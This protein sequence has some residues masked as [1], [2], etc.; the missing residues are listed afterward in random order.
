[1]IA[2]RIDWAELGRAG[3]KVQRRVGGRAKRSKD[4]VE[5]EVEEMEEERERAHHSGSRSR[6]ASELARLVY[7]PT[8]FE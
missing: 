7:S 2:R 3:P 8:A 6:S 5:D 4:E 1:M